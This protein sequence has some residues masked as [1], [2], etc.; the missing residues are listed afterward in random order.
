MALV[1][2]E[3]NPDVMTKFIHQLGVPSKWTLVDVYG[4][5]PDVLAIVPKPTLALILL[6]PHSKKAQDYTS[7]LVEKIK[8]DGQKISPNV[9]HMEQTVSNACG[10]I[11][12]IHAIANNLDQI[13][14][15]DGSLKEFLDK[16]KD[17][18]FEERGKLLVDTASDI[19]DAHEQ[20][21]QEGQTPAPQENAP[22]YYHFVA[23]I[24]K[25]GM[26]YELD[27]RKPFPINNGPTTK[28]KLLENAAKICSEYMARDPEELGF[29]MIALAA[30]NE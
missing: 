15:E 20:L 23:F 7:E 11:A 26:L 2:L 25:D 8:K 6:Y 16:A 9:F 21:A 10:T 22:V 5:D 3:S 27:G 12:L 19:I 4:L 1:P 17:L 18:T 30:A 24:E 29:T 13:K 14:L 28:D